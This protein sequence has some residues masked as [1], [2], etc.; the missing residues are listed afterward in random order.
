MTTRN[1]VCPICKTK[2]LGSTEQVEDQECPTCGEPFSAAHV[3]YTVNGIIQSEREAADILD[4]MLLGM[5]TGCTEDQIWA[6]ETARA[7]LRAAAEKDETS[8]PRLKEHKLMVVLGGQ[9]MLTEVFGN[10]TDAVEAGRDLV[11]TK[12]RNGVYSVL[13][14]QLKWNLVAAGVGPDGPLEAADITE[15]LP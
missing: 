6:M 15:D 4:R 14:R 5:R 10:Y 9:T 1:T 11:R 7:T 8:E 2:M 3:R 13:Q 12:Y